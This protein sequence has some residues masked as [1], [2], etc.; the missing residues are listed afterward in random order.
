MNENHA[1]Q[2][3]LGGSG[4]S[5]EKLIA[6]ALEAGALGAKLAGAG[7]GGTIIALW[8]W[9]DTTRLEEALHRA[10]ASQIYRLQVAPGVTIDQ[11]QRDE[12]AGTEEE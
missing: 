1:I 2:R 12:K 10:G 8:P 4:E 6:A 7:H 5:N 9:S 11:D 3:D